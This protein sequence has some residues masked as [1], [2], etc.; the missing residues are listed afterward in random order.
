MSSVK[1]EHISKI[2]ENN[3]IAL[4]NINI[5]IKQGEFV[6]I[7]GQSG[8]GKTTLLNIIIK[9][10]DVS[11]GKI[12]FD[13][14]DITNIRNKKIPYIRRKMGI[15][16]QRK[17]LLDDKNVYK[18]IE[19]V[20][21]ATER[22]IQNKFNYIQSVLGIVGMREKI[23]SMPYELSGGEY[24]KIE[25]ARAIVNNPKIIIADE[26]TSGLDRDSVWD[27]IS[28]LSDINRRGITIIVSTHDKE[29]VNIM[30]KR[31]ITLYEGKII[32]D[33]KN[34]KYGYLI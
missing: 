28:L 26:P 2:Y 16:N 15:I 6:F 33:V 29:I 27:I 10:L 12:Y 25:L 21:M 13:N 22:K 17:L 14:E 7:T 31:V 5:N 32:G 23:Y 8:S 4:D 19:L 24:S 9:E 34:G 11:N 18:N 3:I 30:K 1:L 20:L